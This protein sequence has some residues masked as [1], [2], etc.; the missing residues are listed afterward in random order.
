MIFFRKRSAIERVAYLLLHFFTRANRL[1]LAEELG[2]IAQYD[3][4]ER[5]GRPFI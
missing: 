1:G 5:A 4:T 2:R 3:A